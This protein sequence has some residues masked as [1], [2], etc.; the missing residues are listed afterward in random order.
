MDRY[1]SLAEVA[2]R[3]GLALNTVRAYERQG[4]LP[5]PDAMT[6]RTR[7]W[8]PETIDYWTKNRVG[9]GHRSDLYPPNPAPGP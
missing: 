4:R 2:E 3:T 8:R 7:G 9:R 5:K 1:L 6:G